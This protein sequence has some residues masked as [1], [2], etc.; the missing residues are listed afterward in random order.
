M[1][2]SLIRPLDS[3]YQEAE[4]LARDAEWNNTDNATQLRKRADSLRD[5][6]EQGELYDLAF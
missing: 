2:S 1:N 3:V 5:R 6:M 4:Q